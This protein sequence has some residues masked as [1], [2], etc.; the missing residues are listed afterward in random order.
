APSIPASLPYAAQ[1][2][3]CFCTSP[4]SEPHALL[5][6]AAIFGA[7]HHGVDVEFH[8]A[9]VAQG[10]GHFTRHHAL[11]PAT[12]QKLGEWAMGRNKGLFTAS[13]DM[14]L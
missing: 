8:Q 9:L 12:L 2:S 13:F 6:L 5:E 4:E 14:G 3:Q 11:R 7:G 1:I 10:L